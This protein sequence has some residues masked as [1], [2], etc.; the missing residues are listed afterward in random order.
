[1]SNMSIFIYQIYCNE[2]WKSGNINLADYGYDSMM[3]R[4][5]YYSNIYLEKNKNKKEEMRNFCFF[6]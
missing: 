2:K 1:M 4:N 6:R 5:I 3:F